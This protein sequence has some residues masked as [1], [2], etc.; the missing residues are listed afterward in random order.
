MTLQEWSIYQEVWTIDQL[1]KFKQS[2]YTELPLTL[3]LQENRY[4]PTLTDTIVGVQ[5]NIASMC[6][7]LYTTCKYPTKLRV[8]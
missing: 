8:N 3:A 2:V 4:T 5:L 6:R 7:N 1:Y